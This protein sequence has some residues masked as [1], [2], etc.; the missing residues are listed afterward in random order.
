[1]STRGAWSQAAGRSSV[2]TSEAGDSSAL[3][4]QKLKMLKTA[5]LHW[6]REWPG[7]IQ[8]QGRPPDVGQRRNVPHVPT[9][10]Q[11][12]AFDMLVLRDGGVASGA[13]SQEVRRSVGPFRAHR[14]LFAHLGHRT[15]RQEYSLA[16]CLHFSGRTNR[17]G[18]RLGQR[19]HLELCCWHLIPHV[20]WPRWFVYF[21]SI[22]FLW[23]RSMNQF[24]FLTPVPLDWCYMPILNAVQ[25]GFD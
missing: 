23:T 22:I 8:T 10:A 9:S 2:N 21:F 18:P 11:F 24:I 12:G 17:F 25:V 3:W 5:I 7:V 14:R 20:L 1:M 15:H 13:G 16:S 19:G 4:L 6:P